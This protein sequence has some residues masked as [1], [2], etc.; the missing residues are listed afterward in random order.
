MVWLA[1]WNGH[2]KMIVWFD[3]SEI[4]AGKWIKVVTEW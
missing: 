4:E 1:N 2:L 3:D